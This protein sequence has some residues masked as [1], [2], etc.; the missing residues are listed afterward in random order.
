MEGAAGFLH[1]LFKRAKHR[2]E[3]SEAIR[4]AIR[5]F[6]VTGMVNQKR[7]LRATLQ[8]AIEEFAELADFDF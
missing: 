1:S 7:V 4:F 5:Q 3:L 2:G 6:R 8:T